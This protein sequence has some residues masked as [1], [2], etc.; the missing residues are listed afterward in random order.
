MEFDIARALESGLLAGWGATST[1]FLTAVLAVLVTGIILGII[2]GLAYAFNMGG[3]KRYAVSEFL[4]LAA[5]ALMVIFLVLMIETGS[6]FVAGLVP[7]QITCKGAPMTEPIGAAMCRTD[8]RLEYFDNLFNTIKELD[9]WPERQYHL[10]ITAYGVPVYQGLWD[11]SVHRTVETYHYIATKISSIMISLNAQ[12][13]V[14]KYIKETML[15]VF[16]P[17]GIVLRVFHFTRGIGGFF[18]SLALALYFIYPSVLFM[19]DSTF[20]APPE[21]PQLVQARPDLCN[22]PVFGGISIAAVPGQSLAGSSGMLINIG[23]ITSFV[24]TVFVRLFYEN[25]VAFAVALTAVRYG[26][27]L[28]GG[29]SGVFLSMVTRWV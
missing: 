9:K 5:T 27:M 6:A 14:L 19:M 25:M 21:V 1:W 8:E 29:E 11:D 22:M 16:L 24:S 3:L 10:S 7:G 28:L 23:N 17:L 4:Q 12:M 26:T 2:Y 18:I 15:A 20:G 13:F